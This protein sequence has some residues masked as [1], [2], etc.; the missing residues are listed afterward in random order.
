MYTPSG[1]YGP[2]Q[3]FSMYL[4]IYITFN[5]LCDYYD[6]YYYFITIQASVYL[7]VKAKI[8]WA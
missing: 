1:L 2:I 8:I 5:S 3:F 7:D 6:L 4:N